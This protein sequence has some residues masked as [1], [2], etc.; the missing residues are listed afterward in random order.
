MGGY[1]NQNSREIKAEEPIKSEVFELGLRKTQS[2]FLVG[3]EELVTA[4]VKPTKIHK[5]KHCPFI[6]ISSANLTSHS[7][8]HR[9]T[10]LEETP[11]HLLSC[12]GCSNTFRAK[13]SLEVH[14]INDHQI[15]EAEL[16]NIVEFANLLSQT[17]SPPNSNRSTPKTRPSCSRIFIKSVDVLRNPVDEGF[18]QESQNRIFLKNVDVLRNPEQV[19]MSSEI[20]QP[21]EQICDS[22]GEFHLE[23]NNNPGIV[24]TEVSLFLFYYLYL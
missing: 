17:K 10:S 24:V 6:T 14:L 23:G 2:P 22:V 11:P 19:D 3:N 12:P 7:D 18:L 15:L 20:L 9:E 4:R 13:K 5:C 8:A 21:Q 1:H 16:D